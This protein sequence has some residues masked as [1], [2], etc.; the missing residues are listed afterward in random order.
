MPII[1]PK[2]KQFLKITM[3]LFKLKNRRRQLC[4]LE[5]LFSNWEDDQAKKKIYFSLISPLILFPARHFLSQD[6]GKGKLKLL[7][8]ATFALSA[9]FPLS[10][11]Y[12][13]KPFWEH[14]GYFE[15]SINR[16]TLKNQNVTKFPNYIYLQS[17]ENQKHLVKVPLK[18]FH[19]NGNGH[20]RVSS[21][22]SKVRT[23]K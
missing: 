12:V 18:K 21:T 1:G 22:D 8:L 19:L 14:A 23:T 17:G 10:V 2:T 5:C 20:H 4:S 7:L 16:S 6:L 3:Q 13:W 15:S 11:V 9:S